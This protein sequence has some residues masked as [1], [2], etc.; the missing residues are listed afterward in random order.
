M[1]TTLAQAGV[2]HDLGEGLVLM[3]VGMGVVFVALVTLWGIVA[4][5]KAIAG[6]HSGPDVPAHPTPQTHDTLT[7]E[8]VAVLT[9]AAAAAVAA[10]RTHPP[11]LTAVIAAAAATALGRPADVRITRITPLIRGDAA[12]WTTGGRQSHMAAHR[13]ARRTTAKG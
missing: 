1:L 12:P 3:A 7:P 4:V 2:G 13:P 8:L 6:D 5:I 10:R 11:E 9:A